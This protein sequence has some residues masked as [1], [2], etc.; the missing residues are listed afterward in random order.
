MTADFIAHLGQL[1]GNSMNMKVVVFDD[2][3]TDETIKFA[4]QIMPNLTVVSLDGNAYWGGAINA[5]SDYIQQHADDHADD[6]LYLLANDDVRFPSKDALFAG[7]NT[8]NRETFACARSAMIPDLSNESISRATASNITLGPSL[9]Y[10][11]DKGAF[12]TA[13]QN[14]PAN[15]AS[16][17]AMFSTKAIW[18]SNLKVPQSIP[19]YLSDYW[20]T[21]NL[22]KLGYHLSQPNEFFCYVSEASTRNN[23]SAVNLKD[24]I[25]L[26]RDRI[27]RNLQVTSPGYGPAW[28]KFLSQEPISA[29]VRK[30][31]IILKAK[32]FIFRALRSCFYLIDKLKIFRE[33]MGFR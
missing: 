13:T 30:K 24:I 12:L 15:V 21:Y 7:I 33:I 32:G 8:T 4:Q 20:F 25:P 26:V 1:L 27:K 28:I 29:L 14:S 5:I 17:W 9:C 23:P 6:M 10:R 16:T 3:S 22:T 18:G 31:L 2:G 11:Q 19:H